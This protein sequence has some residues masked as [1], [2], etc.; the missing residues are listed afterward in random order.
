MIA[1]IGGVIAAAL[2]AGSVYLQCTSS[3][4]IPPKSLVRKWRAETRSPRRP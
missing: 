3:V 1:I 2:I 4:A